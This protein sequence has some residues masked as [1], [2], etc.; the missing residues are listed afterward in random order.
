MADH[1][2]DYGRKW[3]ELPDWSS[4]RLEAEGVAVRAI[5][6]PAQYLVSGDLEAFGRASGCDAQG[7]GA[8]GQTTGEDYSLR[9][10]RDRL[11]VVGGCPGTSPGWNAGGFAVTDVGAAWLVLEVSGPRSMDLLSR[12]STLDPVNP[13]PSA[14]AGFASV[15]VV[16]YHHGSSSTLRI[17]VERGLAGYLWAW[18][19]AVFQGIDD[20]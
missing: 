14:M 6:C 7:V 8:L 16:L 17:H 13:G 10:G 5:E 2:F 12:G 20:A 15:P 1:E 11:M 3:A 9:L 18:F 4:A 19:E